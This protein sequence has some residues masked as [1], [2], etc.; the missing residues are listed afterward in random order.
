[1]QHISHT[2][3]TAQATAKRLT[4]GTAVMLITVHTL[5]VRF[6]VVNL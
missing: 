1:M 6:Y 3:S 4:T 5:Q 2:G